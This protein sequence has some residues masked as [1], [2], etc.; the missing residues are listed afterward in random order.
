MVDLVYFLTIFSWKLNIPTNHNF[1][2]FI[3]IKAREND[4]VDYQIPVAQLKEPKGN[5]VIQA[6]KRD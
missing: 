6:A 4:I 3:K 2:R 5:G 1:F